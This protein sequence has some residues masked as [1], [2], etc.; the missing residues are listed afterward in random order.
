MNP[1]LRQNETLFSKMRL[2][3]AY[4]LA[5]MRLDRFRR[6]HEIT[7]I[8][9]NRRDDGSVVQCRELCRN[10]HLHIARGKGCSNTHSA[11]GLQ[12]AEGPQA[13]PSSSGLVSAF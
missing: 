8:P 2:F 12:S 6:F 13:N 7:C 11:C 9:S 1:F 10:A 3:S 4:R 5:S